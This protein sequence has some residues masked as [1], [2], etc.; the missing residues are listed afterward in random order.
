MSDKTIE[1]MHSAYGTF[2]GVKCRTCPHLDAFT[3]AQVTRC[4]YKCRM[5]GVTGGTGTDWKISYE[6]CGAFRISPG[7]ARRKRLY[8]QVSRETA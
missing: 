3:N 6:A 4:W 5:Y 2:P 7:E 1:A 8:G